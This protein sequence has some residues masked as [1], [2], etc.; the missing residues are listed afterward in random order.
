M[1]LFGISYLSVL[2]TLWPLAL[3]SL[4]RNASGTILHLAMAELSRSVQEASDEEVAH[5]AAA[6]SSS[7][8]SDAA[9]AM[10]IDDEEPLPSIDLQHFAPP[11]KKRRG[12][13]KKILQEISTPKAQQLEP[14][15][16]SKV[17]AE[18]PDITIASAAASSKPSSPQVVP[19][20][21]PVSI[22]GLGLMVPKVSSHIQNTLDG[23][24]STNLH[25]EALKACAHC[26]D[27]PQALLDEDYQIFSAERQHHCSSAVALAEKVGLSRYTIQPKIN[28][29]ASAQLAWLK[30]QKV[31]LDQ[32][33]AL[34]LGFNQLIT[35][36]EQVM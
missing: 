21:V 30:S 27:Q 14:P 1:F 9:P 32:T 5:A 36:V 4:I 10:L 23:F 25:A 29:L 11:T 12:R 8:A 20:V 33:L 7:A 18:S 6:A 3:A 35:Y 15:A 17:S 22:P 31:S 19:L 34:S 13:P 28:R 2:L 16:S 24:A 26:A